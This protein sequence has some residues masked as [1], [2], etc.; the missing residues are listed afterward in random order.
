MST[1]QSAFLHWAKTRP[2][3]KYDLA[4]SGILNLSLGE[5]DVDF[6][7]FELHG[8]NAYGYRSLVNAIAA[9]CNLPS[10]NVVVITGGTSMA[11]HLAMAASLEQG[12]EVLIE[13]PTYEPI[14]AVASY[15][16]ARIKRFRRSFQEAYAVDLDDLERQLTPR[17]RMIVLTNLHNPSSVLLPAEALIQIGKLADTVGARV[18]V[19]EVYLESMLDEKPGSSITL[20]TQFVATGSLTKGYGLSGLRCG[21]ILAESGLAE[22]I[23]RLNDLFG[24]VAPH[25]AEILSVMALNQI[26]KLKERA[27]KF[28]ETNRST[29][30][31]F[32]DTRDDLDVVRTKFGT[33]SF[34]CL[35]RV[36]ADKLCALLAESYE[37]AVVPGRFFESPQHIRIGLCCEPEAFACGL[38]NLGR[39]LDQFR[40]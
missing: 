13:Q 17:T 3:L 30:N 11:N 36:D 33:T 22:K 37:T 31:R 35:R 25:V 10:E 38:D 1:K 8:D 6:N 24:A 23:R 2:K 28:L 40:T 34:P 19:D 5:L 39:A 18:L 9:H 4:V 14:L 20:G 27:S 26:S 12:D 21:W 16:G 7:R 32:F 15:L 29:L